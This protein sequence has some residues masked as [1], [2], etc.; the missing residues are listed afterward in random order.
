MALNLL[1]NV[2]SVSALICFSVHTGALAQSQVLDPCQA[3]EVATEE[4]GASILY[5]I[6]D[7]TA[8]GLGVVHSYEL[9]NLPD[10]NA[11]VAVTTLD[12]TDRAWI[13]VRGDGVPALEEITGSIG[14]I[15]GAGVGEGTLSEESKSP[16]FRSPMNVAG[17]SGRG[18]STDPS[19][20]AALV[21]RSRIVG[22]SSSAKETGQ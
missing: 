10:L 17:L 3:L 5:I 9:T 20:I 19:D 1:R 14:G 6:C 15:S 12:G 18:E 16:S 8:T 2:L 4:V 22:R 13:L 11:A 7:G 21:A